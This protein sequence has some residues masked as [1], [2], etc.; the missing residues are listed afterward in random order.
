MLVDDPL[1]LLSLEDGCVLGALL[2]GVVSS[3]FHIVPY[4]VL[5]SLAVLPHRAIS[6]VAVYTPRWRR[7]GIFF[8]VISVLQFKHFHLSMC[9]EAGSPFQNGRPVGLIGSLSLPF[10]LPR[11]NLPAPPSPLPTAS[12]LLLGPA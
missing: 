12:P 7:F 3:A 10:R 6:S 4:Y 8:P 9:Y 5:V 2:I 1:W 11:S